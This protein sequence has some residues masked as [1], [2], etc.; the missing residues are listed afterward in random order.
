MKIE[1][2]ELQEEFFD[3]LKLDYDLKKKNGLI[4]EAKQKLFIKRII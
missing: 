3:N 1:L 4:S 2:K